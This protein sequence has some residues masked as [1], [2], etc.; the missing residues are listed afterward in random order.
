MAAFLGFLEC[1]CRK[2]RNM[3]PRDARQMQ[4]CTASSMLDPR[5]VSNFSTRHSMLPTRLI[6]NM[7]RLRQAVYR[8]STPV[9]GRSHTTSAGSFG[10]QLSV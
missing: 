2:K 5:H 3:I 7:F 9:Q 1:A 6:P 8:E 10:W 4:R